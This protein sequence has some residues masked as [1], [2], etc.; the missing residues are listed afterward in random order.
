V[1]FSF[2]AIAIVLLTVSE[3]KRVG[4]ARGSRLSML[5][6][7][8]DVEGHDLE[9]RHGAPLF[10]SGGSCIYHVAAHCHRVP[11]QHRSRQFASTPV[12]KL[13]DKESLV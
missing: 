7:V 4:D 2:V 9:V 3:W 11:G 5:S 13:G 12:V 1:R 8:E 10:G 6:V